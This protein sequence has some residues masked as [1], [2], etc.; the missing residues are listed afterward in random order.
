M[1]ISLTPAILYLANRITADFYNIFRSFPC[2][3]YLLSNIVR[4]FVTTSAGRLTLCEYGKAV[5]SVHTPHYL[6]MVHQCMQ[7]IVPQLS[8]S[9]NAETAM[10][11]RPITKTTSGSEKEG[12]NERDATDADEEDIDPSF[13]V[14]GVVPSIT[15]LGPEE[16]YLIINSAEL[17]SALL[18]DDR[19]YEASNRYDKRSDI[20]FNVCS[21]VHHFITLF[22]NCLFRGRQE[23]NSLLFSHVLY[24]GD[25]LERVISATST[26]FFCALELE[27]DCA[28]SPPIGIAALLDTG[29]GVAAE[30][31][32]EDDE[33]MSAEERSVLFAKRGRRKALK[34]RRLLAV[35][36]ID[37]II[38]FWKQILTVS[39]LTPSNSERS[40]QGFVDE[41]HD[42]DP[43]AFKRRTIAILMRYLPAMWS[44]EAVS[45]LPPST[46]RNLLDLMQVSLKSLQDS[47]FFPLQS[48]VSERDRLR[49]ISEAATLALNSSR[50]SARA[51]RR[52][53]TAV[54]AS[55]GVQSSFRV[56]ESSVSILTDMGF[57]A[58][59]I[60]R[61]ASALRTN[62]ISILTTH[63][64][65]VSSLPPATSS[66][67]SG[68][69]LDS[70]AEEVLLAEQTGSSTVEATAVAENTATTAETNSD[71][72]LIATAIADADDTAS[73]AL[74]AEPSMNIQD[75]TEQLL[76]AVPEGVEGVSS[77]TTLIDFLFTVAKPLPLI[78]RLPSEKMLRGKTVLQQILQ[79]VLSM[80]PSSCLRLIERGIV[81]SGGEWGIEV[82][83]ANQVRLY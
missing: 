66:A 37:G 30:E 63:L 81:R 40:L 7:S 22:A 59:D 13:F 44:H 71:A 4:T 83:S 74:D 76:I 19:R 38:D 69:S 35:S 24:R 54:G 32:H 67:V 28:I 29:A 58:E 55:D 25:L 34:E 82:S 1:P 12:E 64:L 65:E 20:D 26:V 3:R 16:M 57:L 78:P 80:V 47:K 56:N 17:C 77:E 60:R 51:S 48:A 33:S 21:H 36:S 15:D 14:S 31:E 68:T 8:V 73:I 52:A 72:T 10:E 11:A 45:T 39:G 49:T 5:I 42:F 62:S 50:A 75:T 2:T 9:T 23:V 41:E 18:F 6:P 46:V 27:P 61:L 70:G 43:Y 53:L 79:K